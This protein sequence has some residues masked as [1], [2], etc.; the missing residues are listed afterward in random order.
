MEG[1]KWPY[2]VVGH[3]IMT[4]RES[5]WTSPVLQTNYSITQTS[6]NSLKNEKEPAQRS[7]MEMMQF[8]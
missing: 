1:V 2:Y 6:H 8:Y 7:L 4:K 3:E 5:P